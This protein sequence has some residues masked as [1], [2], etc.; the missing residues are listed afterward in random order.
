MRR[1]KR[2]RQQRIGIAVAVLA[3][4]AVG[5]GYWAFRDLG[6]DPL[7]QALAGTR[8][9]E[10]SRAGKSPSGSDPPSGDPSI[11]EAARKIAAEYAGTVEPPEPPTA[12]T[13]TR[14]N[15]IEAAWKRYKAGEVIEARH[16][17]NAMLSNSGRPDE[18]KRLRDY[19]AK[20][21][22][23]TIFSS[24]RLENDPLVGTY[25]VESGDFLSV[26]A[27]KY[28][29]SYQ[30]LMRINGIPDATKLRANRN[31]K[32]L[33]GPFHVKIH[34]SD[35]R[36]DLYLQDLYVRSFPVAI[37]IDGGTPLGVWRVK[38][39]VSNPTYY[40]PAS[41]KKKRIIPP[42]DPMNPL[43]EH[44]IGLEGIEGDA[45]GQI[46]YGIHGTIEPESI[47]KAVSLGCVR[48][49]NADVE[50]IFGL[51]R[52]GHSTVTTLP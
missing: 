22:N 33:H 32:V 46:G 44:W 29:L 7:E 23:A 14:L 4:A 8:D 41:A 49:H 50:F 11:T 35:F 26:I 38:D 31:I 15:E 30:I 28:K 18:Q 43:G 48:M 2:R 6:G 45:V 51:V 12:L 9:S 24:R 17:L 34:K 21:A 47:G 25:K 20:I 40:P 42:D 52:P 19:L 39:P 27:K 37:G 5:L 36:L 3:V 1:S 13:A 16:E 10:A